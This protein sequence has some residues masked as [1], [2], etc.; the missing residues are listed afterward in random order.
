ML[1]YIHIRLCLLST[2]YLP[3]A[4]TIFFC[5]G[6]KTLVGFCAVGETE[7]QLE[8]CSFDSLVGRYFSVE[9]RVLCV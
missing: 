9:A 1:D 4:L 6:T 2:C 5:G 3:A 8:Y 7:Q